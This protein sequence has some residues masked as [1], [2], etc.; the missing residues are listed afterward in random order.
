MATEF[1][2]MANELTLTLR[3]L[4]LMANELTLTL[5]MLELMAFELTLTLSLLV[6]ELA[7][8]ELMQRFD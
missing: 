8:F 3:M 1:T 5:R 4:V 2:L 7:V 6:L